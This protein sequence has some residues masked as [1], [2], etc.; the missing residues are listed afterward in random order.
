MERDTS[1]GFKASESAKILSSKNLWK[2]RK[3]KKIRFRRPERI[4]HTRSVCVSRCPEPKPL[5]ATTSIGP[6]PICEIAPTRP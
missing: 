2:K 4:S 1:L 5:R 6:A 3:H